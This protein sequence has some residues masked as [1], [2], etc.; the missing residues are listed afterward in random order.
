MGR[1]LARLLVAA[2]AALGT[3]AGLAVAAPELH[4]A[5]LHL[6]NYVKQGPPIRDFLRI[7]RDRVGRVAIFGIPLQQ[8]W[9]YE[10]S[11]GFAP[12]YYLQTDA[13]LYYSSLHRRLRRD[14]V[15]V[16]DACRAGA[17]RSDDHRVQPGRHVRR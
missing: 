12:T 15:P 16:A 3:A 10:N 2:T 9:S 4:D 8:T 7:M 11:G 13:P 6:T 1:L 14:G 17:L 5:H